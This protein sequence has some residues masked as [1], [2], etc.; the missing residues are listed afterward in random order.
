MLS[1]NRL[2]TSSFEPKSSH[3]DVDLETVGLLIPFNELQVFGT[4]T[5]Q[6]S[7]VISHNPPESRRSV[8]DQL[9]SVSTQ[10]LEKERQASTDEALEDGV[11]MSVWLLQQFR[12]E[13]SWQD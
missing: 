9:D 8:H 3:A 4:S 2:Q 11:R 7:V 5:V 13:T 1:L 6:S 10:H 12:L